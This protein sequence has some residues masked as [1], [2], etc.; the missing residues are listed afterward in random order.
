MRMSDLLEQLESE[1]TERL[2]DA[3]GVDRAYVRI[4]DAYNRKGGGGALEA[5]SI[6]IKAMTDK[7]KRAAMKK[8]LQN[9]LANG[10]T[11]GLTVSSGAE[12]GEKLPKWSLNATQKDYLEMLI[13]KL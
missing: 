1:L 9:I 13:A 3:E 2:T 12:R 4:I 6:R 11:T 7:D 10:G 5:I 8:A